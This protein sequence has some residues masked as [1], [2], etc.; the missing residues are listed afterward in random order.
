MSIINTIKSEKRARSLSE[1]LPQPANPHPKID[2]QYLINTARIVS[3]NESLSLTKMPKFRDLPDSSLLT[4]Y[5]LVLSVGDGIARVFGLK[6][7][8]SGEMVILGYKRIKG[9]AINLEHRKVGV[10]IFGND[11]QVKQGD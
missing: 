2:D 6:N 3:T 9:M 1:M 4:D 10:V 7:I 11:R 8:A 5:G